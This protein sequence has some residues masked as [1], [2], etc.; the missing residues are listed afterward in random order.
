VSLLVQSDGKII[1]DSET[2][3]TRYN[4]DGSIDTSYGNQ[5][6]VSFNRPDASDPLSGEA[7][8]QASD[9]AIVVAGCTGSWTT[10]FYGVVMRFVD[11]TTVDSSNPSLDASDP[12]A[13][14]SAAA[15]QSCLMQMELAAT[16]ESLLTLGA[17]DSSPLGLSAALVAD[18]P[19]RLSDIETFA[20]DR[21]LFPTSSR[22]SD[23]T[24]D[25]GFVDAALSDPLGGVGNSLKTNSLLD[26]NDVLTPQF[27]RL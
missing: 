20:L 21:Q 25:G 22:S 5:G 13:L 6:T 12:N 4:A 9:G 14:L 2:G 1:F 16:G 10:G 27:Y 18:S 17:V 8:A 23:L 15:A 11:F 7:I 24:L 19:S 3:L 26:P